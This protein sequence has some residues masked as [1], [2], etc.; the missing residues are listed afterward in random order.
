[1]KSVVLAPK[2]SDNLVLAGFKPYSP[3]LQNKTA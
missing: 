2:F 1:M 3:S